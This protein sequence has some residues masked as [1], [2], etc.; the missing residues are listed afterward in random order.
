[1]FVFLIEA[2]NGSKSMEITIANT[3]RKMG[4]YLAHK[5]DIIRLFALSILNSTFSVG[6][7]TR[8]RIEMKNLS[9]F[10]LASIFVLLVEMHTR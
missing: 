4:K 1:M 3:Y 7:N 2:T 8:K 9:L 10:V 6:R 5:Y